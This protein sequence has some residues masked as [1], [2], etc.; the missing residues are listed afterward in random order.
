MKRSFLPLFAVAGLLAGSLAPSAQQSSAVSLPV[1]A[2]VP[3]DHP[4]VPADAALLWMRPTKADTARTAA[5]DSFATAVKLETE[6]SSAKALPILAQPLLRTHT[7][8]RYAQYYRG[9]V[10]LSLGQAADARRTFRAFTSDP[11]VGFL[12]EAAALGEAESD[13]GLGDHSA[14]LA[15]YERLSRMKTTA[16]DDVLMRVGRTAESVGDLDKALHAY[17]Q[18]HYE[19]PFSDLASAADL[20][21]SRLPNRPALDAARFRRELE[22]AE[23]LFTG[24]RYTAARTAFEE[25]RNA[26][27]GDDRELVNLRLAESDYYLKRTRAARDGVK[28]YIEKAS[29]QGEAL[30][31]YAVS[32]YDLGERFE[33]FRVVRRLADEFPKQTWAEEALNHLATH[34]IVDDEDAKADETFREMLARYPGGRYAERA[35]WKVGWYAYRNQRYAETVTVFERGAARFP[36][37]DYRPS[38]LYW[39]A[40]AYDALGRKD[41]AEARY[42]LTATDYYNSYYGRLALTR[43]N[44]A[45]AR[46]RLTAEARAFPAAAQGGDPGEEDSLDDPLPPNQQVIRALL[47]LGLYEQAVNELRYAQRVWG[48][49]PAIQATLAWTHWKQGQAEKGGSAQFQL[50]RSSINTMKRAYPQY[51]AV[52]GE[53]LPDE[54]LRVIFPLAYWDLIQKHAAANQ[55]DP[56]LVAAL[57]AQ[58]STFVRDIRSSAR[59]VGLM[60]LMPATARRVAQKL[61]IRYSATLLTNPEANIRLGTAYFAQNTKEFGDVSLAL[62]SYNA[63][64]RAVRQWIA[65][66]PGLPRDEFIDDIPYPETQTYVKRILGTAEDYKRLYGRES[67]N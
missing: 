20:A 25:L 39:S 22:R 49:S 23:K 65:E 13:E 19:F 4:L 46:G 40:R 55:L 15:I 2:L 29:R 30:Y 31:F 52:E 12:A 34:Y 28:P 27:G 57:V 51:L 66:R 53:Q 44:A 64:E 59:A 48:D 47:G 60:Q 10:Q 54:I 42:L 56:Y 37:S 26:A 41:L 14:A 21:L 5:L 32:L 36:R 7:L 33:Y 62:A 8:S 11:P 6:G 18:V 35:A 17:S 43:V 3:T 1:V 63:G 16:P 9:L 61:K 50:Y 24:R 58:E 38:W 67:G 45:A